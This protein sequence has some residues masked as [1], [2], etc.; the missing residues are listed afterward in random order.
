[1]PYNEEVMQADRVFQAE[2]T[3]QNELLLE[4]A[5]LKF[6]MEKLKETP[7]DKDIQSRIDYHQEEIERLESEVKML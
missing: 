2:S 1:M 7:D 5:K 4:K 3:K 6:W